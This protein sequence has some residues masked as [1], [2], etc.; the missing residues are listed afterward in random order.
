[1]AIDQSFFH[2]LS[3]FFPC[4][5]LGGILICQ[6]VSFF[7]PL[8]R[9][10]GVPGVPGVPMGPRAHSARS[11]H[12]AAAMARTCGG[13]GNENSLKIRYLV[14]GW[15][16]HLKKLSSSSQLNGKIR[17]VPNHQLDYPC[18]P[19][20]WNIYLHDRAIF[21]VNVGKYS[22]TMEHMGYVKCL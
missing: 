9:S 22:S 11:F 6:R 20:C 15:A 3:W 1:M 19:W 18:A 2:G 4:F 7:H 8:I 12:S 10:L 21:G 13:K 17:N 14:G 16:T 5:S